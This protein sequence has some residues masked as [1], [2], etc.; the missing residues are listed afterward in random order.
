MSNDGN[1]YV[2][3]STAQNLSTKI[4]STLEKIRDDKNKRF[5]NLEQVFFFVLNNE[6][7]DD[8][9][10]FCEN[11]LGMKNVTVLLNGRKIKINTLFEIDGFRA[12]LAGRTGDVVCFRGGLQLVV[13]SMWEEY[14]KRISSFVEKNN[15]LVRMKKIRIR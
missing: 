3:V 4:K 7:V 11:N 1:I 9:K 8:I 10:D 14:I 15:E 5:K 12:Y 2:Q 6:S 13:G